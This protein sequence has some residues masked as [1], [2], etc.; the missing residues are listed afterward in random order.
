MLAGGAERRGEFGAQESHAAGHLS[1]GQAV[2]QER[3]F[4]LVL[5]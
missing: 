4:K 2:E 1:G 3:P 5:A